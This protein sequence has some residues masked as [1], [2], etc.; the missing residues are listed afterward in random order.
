MMQ[1]YS[2][3][4]SF[5][6]MSMSQRQ[7]M[8]YSAKQREIKVST[9]CR[10]ISAIRGKSA[11]DIL[12]LCKQENSIPVDLT[13]IL[14]KLGISSM[15]FDF[16]GMESSIEACSKGNH[17]LGALATNGNRAAIFYNADDDEDGH[18]Y[19]FTIAHELGHCCLNH[20]PVDGSTTHLVFRTDGVTDDENEVAANIFAGQL[21]IP[22]MSLLDVINRLYAPSVKN[23]AD[24]FN[25]SEPVMRE[26]L[27]YLNL[28]EKILGYNT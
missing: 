5:C 2:F 24:I 19:R 27:K 23:L 4:Q 9:M 16:S 20:F 18:R 25:V 1:E 10:P 22:R 28:K 14:S 17:I 8:Q 13:A 21:L 12:R 26:R 3:R 7:Y 11:Q 15:A 6:N